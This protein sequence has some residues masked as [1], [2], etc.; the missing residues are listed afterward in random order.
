VRRG[1][2]GLSF[3]QLNEDLESRGISIEV[4]A[5][6]D[7]THLGGSCLTEQL[8]HAMKL[9]RTVLREPT[10]AADE[11]AS[12]RQ[13]MLN[14]LSLQQENP[15]S[16]AQ[17][18]QMEALYGKT[19]QG[20]H[21]TP[22]TVGRI[23]L[24]DV[25]AFYKLTYRP[26]DAVLVISGDVTAERGRQL[27]KAL[28][29]DWPAAPMAA[30]DYTL[31]KPP[32]KRLII[33]VDRPEG[34]QST[35]RLGIRSYDLHDDVKFA[36]DLASRIL[37]SGIDSRLGRYVRAEKGL[38][39]SVWGM[40]RP[41]RHGGT[42]LGGTDTKIPSTA[43]AVTSM[44]KVF[45]DLRAADVTDAELKEA[46]LRVSGS[47]VMGMQTIAQQ[48]GY[49]VEGI[50]NG[51]PIDYYDKYPARISQVTREQIREVMDKYV[52]S[53][54]M[55]VVVVAPA[56]QVKEQLAPLGEVKVLPMPARRGAAPA[57]AGKEAKP[58]AVKPAA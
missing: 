19:P 10:F 28:L 7:A 5:G 33:V 39:Y 58:A 12:R 13:Q 52:R 47:M 41:G 14:Q 9:S 53:D 57:P 1:A 27:A 46:K 50:L 4:S 49:R 32:E 8:D 30:V 26:N 45:D 31:P 40:F 21:E 20:I 3:A 24:D 29:A 42:F 54:R 44:F 51:Y 11:F 23:T 48:A 34:Q 16:V 37:S 2:G 36:G 6:D 18:D 15:S 17:D 55:V 56:A 35:V 43:D 38:A 25:K 22:E